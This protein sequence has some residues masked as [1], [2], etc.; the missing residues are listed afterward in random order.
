MSAQIRLTACYHLNHTAVT[1]FK[2]HKPLS[3]LCQI[4]IEEQKQRNSLAFFS[5]PLFRPALSDRKREVGSILMS[6]HRRL[7][8]IVRTGDITRSFTNTICCAGMKRCHHCDV[9]S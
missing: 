4:S 2:G 7:V 6:I 3:I 5:S 8:P 9:G 1:P